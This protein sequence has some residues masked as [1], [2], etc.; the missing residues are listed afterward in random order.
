VDVTGGF[1]DAVKIAAKKA[2]VEDDYKVRLYPRQK[3]FFEKL[4]GDLEQN[5]RTAALK[6]ELGEYY[7]WFRQ[8]QKVRDYQGSQ[9]RMPFEFKIR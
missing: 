9:A 8:W 6:A 5:A 2:G 4:L 3:N 1:D 7:G